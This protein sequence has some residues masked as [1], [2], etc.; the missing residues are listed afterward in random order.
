MLAKT[1]NSVNLMDPENFPFSVFIF[2][3]DGSQWIVDLKGA[4]S[5]YL[6]HVQNNL[7]LKETWK[8]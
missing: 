3:A 6:N 2:I 4:Q 8:L 7:K 1:E 5:R